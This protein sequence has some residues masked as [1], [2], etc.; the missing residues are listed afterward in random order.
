MPKILAVDDSPSIRT[1]V[2]MILECAGFVALMAEGG[3]EAI[4]CLKAV[5]DIDL[6]ILDVHMPEKD[7]LDVLEEMRAGGSTL[8]VLMLTSDARPDL[9]TRARRAGARGWVLKPVNSEFLVP[10]VCR[11]LGLPEPPARV[12]TMAPGKKG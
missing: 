1:E 9:L 6:V 4:A 5:P 7:G 3:L 8:P 12:V 10:V 2:A 11:I